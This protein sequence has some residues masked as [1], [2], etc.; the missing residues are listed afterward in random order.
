MGLFG[1][2]FERK[3]CDICGEEIKLFKTELI[4]ERMERK[5]V[6][7]LHVLLMIINFILLFR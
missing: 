6:T 4:K 5:L 7:N 3:V 2:L 1:K